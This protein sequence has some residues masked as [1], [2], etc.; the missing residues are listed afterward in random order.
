[1]T[2]GKKIRCGATKFTV[3]VTLLL[4]PVESVAAKVKTGCPSLSPRSLK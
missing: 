3:S 2:I 1:L 4:F